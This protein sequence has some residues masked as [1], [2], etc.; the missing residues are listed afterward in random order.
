MIGNNKNKCEKSMKTIFVAIIILLIAMGGLGINI[1]LK[2]KSSIKKC[3]DCD[4]K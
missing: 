3:S 4:C 2:R 1:I